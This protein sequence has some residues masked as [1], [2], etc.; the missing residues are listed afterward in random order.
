MK[1]QAIFLL[2]ISTFTFAEEECVFRTEAFDEF[3]DQYVKSHEEAKIDSDRETLIVT[4]DNEEILVKGGGCIHLGVAIE[5]RT[6]QA[7]TE[8]QF[9]Q[10]TLNLTIEFGDWLINTKELKDAIENGEYH[11]IDGTYYIEV[12]A[13]TVF[14]ASYDNQGKINV[15]FYIN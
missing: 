2:L 6:K 15:D 3:R 9:L 11:K 10:K 13:M 4:R 14:N 1:L 7:Y 5:L 12:D 8:E